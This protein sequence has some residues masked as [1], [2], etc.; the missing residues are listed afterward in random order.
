MENVINRIRS[1]EQLTLE[2]SVFLFHITQ[3][4]HLRR[5]SQSRWLSSWMCD[6][7]FT[8]GHCVSVYFGGRSVGLKMSAERE[9][10]EYGTCAVWKMRSLSLSEPIV[11]YIDNQKSDT[12]LKSN[13]YRTARPLP[14]LCSHGIAN[15][16]SARDYRRIHKSDF[17]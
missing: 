17:L 9:T 12:P 2:T 6:G 14:L 16:F 7:I 8:S 4:E 1:E 3:L 13:S 11:L 5:R 15:K 10:M